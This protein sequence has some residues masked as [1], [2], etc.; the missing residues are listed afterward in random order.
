MANLREF[1]EQRRSEILRQISELKA[2]LA[3]LKLAEAAIKSGVIPAGGTR[4]DTRDRGTIKEMVV[5][6]L[7]GRPDG[8]EASD[9]LQLI[10]N[11][12]GE[13]IPRSSLSPQLSRLKEEGTIVLHG[14]TWKLSEYDEGSDGET[15][16]PSTE[17]GGAV[18]EPDS[19]IRIP[20][21]ANPSTSTETVHP[22]FT[23]TSDEDIPF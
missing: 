9:I 20:E 8:A 4:P 2:E 7:S 5:D 1:I 3:E 23:R 6:V 11:S 12:F 10:L 14:R 21:G 18:R 19:S 13:E 15:S 16:E 22:S 17:G